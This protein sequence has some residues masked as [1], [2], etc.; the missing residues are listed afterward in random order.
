MVS[1][2]VDRATRPPDGGD[3]MTDQQTRPLAL[4]TGASSGIGYELARQFAEH[5]YDV[6]VNAEDARV[7][8]AA[9][10]LGTL[11]V[12]VEPVQAD[13]A[14]AEG[15][16]QLYARVVADGRPLAAAAINAGI[17]V[18]GPFA[19]TDLASE[20]RLVDLNVRS[21]VHLAKLCVRDMV[22]RQQGRILFT[23]SIA[24]TLP[25]PFQA[26]YAAS[27]AFL[28]SLSEALRNELADSGVSVT[29]LMP[30]PT[31]TRFFERAGLEDTKLGAGDKD[32]PAQVAAKGYAAL[33]DGAD[34]VVAGSAKNK[35]MVGANKVLPQTAKAQM[36]RKLSEP[37][38]ADR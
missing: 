30:G 4:V 15:V 6:I 7:V 16:E 18:G 1:I 27:K 3:T 22:A 34:H 26:T 17:G 23:S 38:S 36:H 25:G 8:E 5:G 2:T 12:R 19:E 20:L 13:L 31:E 32:D 37:G 11:G 35:A 28:L 21:S 10:E 14:T 33:M 29:A 24:A 9:R